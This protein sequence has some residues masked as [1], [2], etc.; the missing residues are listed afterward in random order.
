MIEGVLVYLLFEFV[1]RAPGVVQDWVLDQFE[2]AATG[3]VTNVP[4]PM[5]TLEFA[6]SE[7]SDVLVWAPE[8]NDQGLSLSI[9]SYDG[10]IRVGVAADAG[11][12]DEP[13]RLADALEEELAERAADLE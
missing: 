1:G 5:N 12:L 8:A 4:G 13:S 6:G 2:D 7:V 11:L 9:F 3:V 10:S